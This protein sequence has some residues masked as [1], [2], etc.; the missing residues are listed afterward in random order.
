[1]GTGRL[2]GG[3][4]QTITRA[5]NKCLEETNRCTKYKMALKLFIY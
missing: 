4:Q 3:H 2:S 1:M 5:T